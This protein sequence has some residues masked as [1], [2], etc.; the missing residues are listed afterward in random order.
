M[1][2]YYLT[3]VCAL[4]HLSL[5]QR[6]NLMRLIIFLSFASLAACGQ[7]Q[8]KHPETYDDYFVCKKDKDCIVVPNRCGVPS[9]IHKKFS[10]SYEREMA[11]QAMTIRCALPPEIDWSKLSAVCSENMCRVIGT[12]EQLEAN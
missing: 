1:K 7:P 4:P 10:Q 3:D 8:V 12:E 11:I 9:A 2:I 5:T 6:G